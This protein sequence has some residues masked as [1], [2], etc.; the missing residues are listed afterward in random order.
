MPRYILLHETS[1]TNSYLSRMASILPS[2]TVIYTNSQTSGRGQRG[3]S[4]EAEPGKNLTFSMLVKQ[5]AVVPSK[6]FR[7][8]EAVSLAVVEW[9][10]QYSDGFSVKWPNDIYY[11]DKKIC[12]ILIEHVL[13]GNAI[14]HTIVGV[15]INVNQQHFLSDAPNPVSLIHVTGHEIPLEPALHEV[16]E[17]IETALDFSK[18]D[19]VAFATLHERYV[20]SMYRNDGQLHGFELPSGERFHAMIADVAESGMLKLRHEDGSE[21]EYAFKEVAYLI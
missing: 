7:I 9:L 20:K 18:A 6:Q 14:V 3:N 17:R 11:N 12:G 16:C 13:C 19:D 2:G 4:W 10:S 21:R 8:S 1:S 15:G 5:P